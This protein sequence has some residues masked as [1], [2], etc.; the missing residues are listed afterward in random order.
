M[1]KIYLVHGWGGSDSSEGWFGWLKENAKKKGFEV[2]SFNMP[3]TE[4]PVIKEWVGFLKENANKLDEETYFIG[5][6]VGCQA[7]LRYLENLNLKIKI[8][9]CI[10]VVGALI[11][12]A[13]LVL[14][15]LLFETEH[16]LDEVSRKFYEA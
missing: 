8:K 4:T 15:S 1:K 7:I 14:Q 6:S 16:I 13:L 12:R 3:N 10:F 11:V 9:G 2:I 5:H